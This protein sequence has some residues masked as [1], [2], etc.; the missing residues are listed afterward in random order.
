MLYLNEVERLNKRKLLFISAIILCIVVLFGLNEIK[1]FDG[2]YR[3]IEGVVNHQKEVRKGAKEIAL[4]KNG[5]GYVNIMTLD[6]SII[7]Y[8][9]KSKNTLTG[10]KYS[11]A[12]IATKTIDY[13]AVS[14]SIPDI[15]DWNVFSKTVFNKPDEKDLY[16]YVISVSDD[17]IVGNNIEKYEYSYNGNNYYLLCSLRLD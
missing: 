16:W 1:S 15:Y 13:D 5:S 6:N 4:I 10:K 8:S 12:H 17:L 11:I 14:E 9:F 7:F 3:T 2:Y